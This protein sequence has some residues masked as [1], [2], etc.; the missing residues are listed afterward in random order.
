LTTLAGPHDDGV[1]NELAEFTTAC[2]RRDL[3]MLMAL[4]TLGAVL[5]VVDGG[6][7]ALLLFM[8][9]IGV[10]LISPHASV[11]AIA[12]ATPFIYHPVQLR[13]GQWS[14]LELTI[15]I[16]AVSVGG[17][18]ALHILRT[19][20]AWTTLA[21]ARPF[22]TLAA[23]VLLVLV[24]AVSLLTVADGR[25]LSDSVREFRWVIVEPVIAFLLFRWAFR[26]QRTRLLIFAGF[27]GTAM[28]LAVIGII[29]LLTQ[30]GVVVADGVERATGPYRH[31]NNLALYLDRAAIFV[32]A[33]AVTSKQHRRLFA[34]CAAVCGF[35]LAA[36]LSRGA[37]IAYVAGACW[38]VGVARI[39]RGWWWIGLGVA[40]GAVV[41]GL[42]GADRLTD[43]GS[44][45][46]RSSRE[47]IWSASVDM[48]SDHPITGIG[49]DQFV[50]QYGR[51]YVDPAGWAE[52]Y[53]SHPH[54]LVL[55]VWLRLGIT[56][57]FVFAGIAA[58][59]ISVARRPV[60]PGRK[61]SIWIGAT[62]ALIAGLVHGM[63][64]NGF[65]LPDLAVLTW[66]LIALIESTHQQSVDMSCEANG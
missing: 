30:T 52:R 65:F 7:I 23:S 27:V 9:S 41:I 31:P 19:R 59:V 25:Y 43:T 36:T 16:S 28:L 5:T 54:N 66:M 49:L 13:G 12:V 17:H 34:I 56:G 29:Q 37:A 44:A 60:S 1:R 48:I 20:S 18:L 38:I 47:L 35:G 24:G 14:L 15:L 64:D 32:L 57:L 22:S 21:L 10:A 2:F 42:I 6:P 53:T 11:A 39:R 40:L 8:T 33:L 4:T 62:A 26:E 45:G 55:D 3:R 46:S 63:L 58:A 50:T 51:R 61:R